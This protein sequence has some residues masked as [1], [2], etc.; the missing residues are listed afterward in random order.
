M[1]QEEE[2]K[3]GFHCFSESRCERLVDK[4]LRSQAGSSMWGHDMIN[5]YEVLYRL[6]QRA[7][8]TFMLSQ[9]LQILDTS[10]WRRLGIGAFIQDCL[11]CRAL[12]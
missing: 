10:M 8:F 7:S 5:P 6:C 1:E 9:D 4:H 3:H 12:N 11:E 2:L